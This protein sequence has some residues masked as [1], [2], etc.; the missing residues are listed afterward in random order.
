MDRRVERS[1]L[2]V[3][4]SR[5]WITLI[6]ALLGLSGVHLN[7]CS[8][9]ETFVA[10]NFVQGKPVALPGRPPALALCLVLGWNPRRGGMLCR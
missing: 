10:R 2:Y 8:P 1:D 6:S 5:V 7:P 4:E 9:A 3:A